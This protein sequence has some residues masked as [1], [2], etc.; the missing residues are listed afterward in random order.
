VCCLFLF[1][2][3]GVGWVCCVFVCLG[4]VCVCGLGVWLWCVC[5]VVVLGVVLGVVV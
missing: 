5:G 4:V 1:V 2:V 3:C